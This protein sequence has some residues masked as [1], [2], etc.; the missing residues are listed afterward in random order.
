MPALLSTDNTQRLKHLKVPTLVLWA[1]EDAIFYDADE[2]ELR[3]SLDVAVSH[4]RTEYYFKQYGKRPLSPDGLQLD[5]IGHNTQWGAP[6]EVAK[7]IDSYL[8]HGRPTKDWYYSA[9]GDPRQIVTQKN[10]APIIHGKPPK[11]CKH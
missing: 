7:D 5:D 6:N 11:S 3:A 8:R 1:T 9:D 2:Q 4:C 10:A